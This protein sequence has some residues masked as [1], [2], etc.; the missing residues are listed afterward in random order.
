MKKQGE[1]LFV[2]MEL[3]VE[4]DRWP[5][6]LKKPKLFLSHCK[7]GIGIQTYTAVK[8]THIQRSSFEF[9]RKI[10]HYELKT[11]REMNTKTVI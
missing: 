8:H 9:L 2:S 3:R 7:V 1:K 5:R 4:K 6:C 11:N 10:S